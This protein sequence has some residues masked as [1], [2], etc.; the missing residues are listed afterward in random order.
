MICVEP[1]QTEEDTSLIVEE[2][3]FPE[4]P[5]Q[6]EPALTVEEPV[7]TVEEPVPTVEEPVEE[8]V[9][10]VEEPVP[11]GEEPALTVEEPV[12]ESVPTVEEPTPITV[13]LVEEPVVLIKKPINRHKKPWSNSEVARL[14]RE[15]QINRYTIDQI[16]EMHGRTYYSIVGKLKKENILYDVEEEEEMYL[17]EDEEEEDQLP[18]TVQLNTPF[19]KFARAYCYAVEYVVDTVFSAASRLYDAVLMSRR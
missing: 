9:P 5:N 2:Y 13:E 7:P 15:Y 17:Q 16:A 14:Y 19:L 4:S 10:T 1:I 6:I 11:T 12:E 3:V 8:S 18:L